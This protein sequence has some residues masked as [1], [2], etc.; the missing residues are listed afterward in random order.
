MQQK[1][2]HKTKI[3]NTRQIFPMGLILPRMRILAS[4][5]ARKLRKK[6]VICSV[7]FVATC[8]KTKIIWNNISMLITKWIL[9]YNWRIKGNIYLLA[10]RSK[11]K[12][13]IDNENIKKLRK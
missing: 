9:R 11:R 1:I 7:K 2:V 6:E 4:S 8:R 5:C 3:R 10:R 13:K 12:R